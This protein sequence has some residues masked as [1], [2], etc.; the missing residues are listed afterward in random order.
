MN[1]V[2]DSSRE[3]VCFRCMGRENLERKCME[4]H[5]DNQALT[6]LGLRLMDEE[7]WERAEEVFR[8]LLVSC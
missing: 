8:R 5:P 2:A 4:E 7:D 3:D 1:D 6:E